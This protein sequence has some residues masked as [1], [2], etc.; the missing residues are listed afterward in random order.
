MYG[1][2]DGRLLTTYTVPQV[3]IKQH[4]AVMEEGVLDAENTILAI[5][6]SPMMYAGP[7]E[8]RSHDQLC[9]SHDQPST[10]GVVTLFR[11]TIV[12]SNFLC[13]VIAYFVM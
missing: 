6:P 4:L 3:R 1:V 8:V 12:I 2:T 11:C 9:M 13:H 10:T 7:T 5:F